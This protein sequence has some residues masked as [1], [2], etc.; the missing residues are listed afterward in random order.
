ML[1]PD[2]WFGDVSIG[3]SLPFGNGLEVVP[4]VGFTALDIDRDAITESGS[5]PFLLAVE[6]ISHSAAIVDFGIRLARGEESGANLRPFVELGARH[7]FEG[8][9]T[10]SIAA[11]GGGPSTLLGVSPSRSPWVGQWRGHRRDWRQRT[12]TVCL[13]RGGLC[14]L[15]RPSSFENWSQARPSTGL[16][17]LRYYSDDQA[18]QGRPHHSPPAEGEV[19]DFDPREP[20]RPNPA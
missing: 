8:R 18:F 12:S 19:V 9:D 15:I 14:F 6:D 17:G 4:S 3:Y 1:N 16:P 7:Q 20:T 5:S 10:G 13:R 2:G 11:L